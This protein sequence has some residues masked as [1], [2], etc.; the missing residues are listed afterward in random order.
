MT[1]QTETPRRTR[2][3]KS[4]PETEAEPQIVATDL[5]AEAE[6]LSNALRTFG[7]EVP[8]ETI[9]GWTTKARDQIKLVA[10]AWNQDMA[11]A[12]FHRATPMADRQEVPPL[13]VQFESVSA[14]QT[15]DA[16]ACGK[17]AKLEGD[18]LDHNA[19]PPG[20][21]LAV[22]WAESFARTETTSSEQPADQLPLEPA[23]SPEDAKKADAEQQQQ[24]AIEAAQDEMEEALAHQAELE[25]QISDMKAELKELKSAFDNAGQRARRAV[26]ALQRAREG[27]F[28]RTLPFPKDD[29]KKQS[30]SMQVTPGRIVVT[31]SPYRDEGAFVSLDYLI[32]GQLQEFIPGTPEDRGLSEK[33]VEKL[34]EAVGGETIGH[35]EKFQQSKGSW[36]T[37][38]IGGF[39]PEN[40]TKLQDAQ[41]VIRR[42]F[43]VPSP[44]DVAQ[45][46]P[47]TADECRDAISKI[48]NLLVDCDEVIDDEETP[49]AGVKY[50]KSVASQ[51]T[52]MK[53]VIVDSGNVT[54]D[55]LRAIT[56]WTHGV[57]NWLDGF[58]D[59]DLDVDSDE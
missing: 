14:E 16:A 34:K 8:V 56:N 19:Y 41:E 15:A 59:S 3:A 55:Q 42:K 50:C 45:S 36:W 30:L 21:A 22:V 51:A 43:P 24:L 23:V 40:I 39:G 28:E 52:S 11:N 10:N 25:T 6:M 4:E 33:Q 20:S 49:P 54:E 37:K 7:F 32:K 12:N 46:N 57:S 18:T 38:E 53:S 48:Q 5:K 47:Q 35:L 58:D 31:Q 44:E 27:K 17:T 9:A 13:L 2:K 26:R 29:G 1:T